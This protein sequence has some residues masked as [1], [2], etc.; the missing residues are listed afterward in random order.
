MGL[1]L[2]CRRPRTIS[3]EALTWTVAIAAL[4]LFSE[5]VGPNARLLITAFPA[6][7]VFADRLRT[8]GYGWF[9][10][11][12]AVLLVLMSALTFTGHSLTP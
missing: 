11:F 3:P 7:L 9:L 2:L 6:V 12:N 8:R 5:H 4:A 1:A 10:G